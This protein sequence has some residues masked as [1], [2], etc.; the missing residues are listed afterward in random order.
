MK[1][2]ARSVCFLLPAVLLLALAPSAAL[3]E[4]RGPIPGDPVVGGLH[5]GGMTENQ[6]RDILSSEV[7]V[8]ALPS[9]EVTADTLL[10]RLSPAQ[11]MQVDVSATLR[12]AYESTA[13]TTCVLPVRYSIDT[14]AL[15]I[16]FSKV[17]E[18]VDRTVVNARY[19]ASKSRRRLTVTNTITGRRT[20]VEAG[21]DLVSAALM[22]ALESTASTQPTVGIPVVFTKPKITQRNIGKGIMVDLK[23]R[24][25]YLYDNG[26]L[27]LA[28]KCAIGQ[29]QYPT[30]PGNWKIVRK[31]SM[32]TWYN[33]GSAWA[34]GMPP[35]IGPGPS[36]PLGTR[37]LY[38][39]ADGIRIHGTNNIRSIGTPASHGC[40]RLQRKDI[41]KLYPLVPVGTPAFIIK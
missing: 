32:P 20:D 6:A 31:V 22:T 35:Y 19:E 12:S 1:P 13:T 7:T 30:P 37:A 27:K 40:V 38:L 33:P 3:G 17:R 4:G 2:L 39:N 16:W 10:Y 29:P 26:V 5:L 21:M 14:T 34:K 41:E 18:K 25:V 28:F 15:V 23:K 11:V 8:P 36:N 9:L 24:S